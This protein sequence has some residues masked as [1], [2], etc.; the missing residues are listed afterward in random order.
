MAIEE[1]I[2]DY[3][4]DGTVDLK[5][6]PVRRSKRGG[7]RACSFV[8]GN[9]IY[10]SLHSPLLYLSSVYFCLCVNFCPV[11][12]PA[13]RLSPP[14]NSFSRKVTIYICPWNLEAIASFSQIYEVGSSKLIF[15]IKKKFKIIKKET[16]SPSLLAYMFADDLWLSLYCCHRPHLINVSC[17]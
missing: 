1:G 11:P 3:T 8:V 10:I 5:G 4:Q 15:W 14:L 9:Y 2:E 13:L 17:F 6:N 16:C 12:V 7:W